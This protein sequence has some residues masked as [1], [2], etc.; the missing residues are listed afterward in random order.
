MKYLLVLLIS[1]SLHAETI[2]LN[3]DNTITLDQYYNYTTVSNL[4]QS[5]KKLDSKLTSK[6]PI[7][8]VL[9]SGGGS[10]AAGL[11][12]IENLNNLN[13]PV[14]TVTVFAASMGF[15]TVQGL[16]NRY[17]LKNGTLMTHKAFGGFSGEF[18][19]QLDSRYEYYLRKLL[20]M[21]KEVVARTNGVH[22]LDSYKALY[23]NEYWCDGVD[24][25][26]QGFADKVVNV[27]CDDSLSGTKEILY[28]RFIYQGYPVEIYILKSNCPLI[29][30]I[31]G[32][33]VYIN[34]QELFNKNT[35]YNDI[36]LKELNLMIDNKLSNV[37]KRIVKSEY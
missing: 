19:G 16:K 1:F 6:D 33:K 12:G 24:C 27:K 30:G 10:I 8:L 32:S 25:V 5:A 37:S 29:T 26:K 17:I 21:D 11:E 18:P 4:T 36:N 3:K 34:G 15:H 13:R 28:N 2:T 23:E 14:H 35:I 20:R 31:L 7:Y 22:T 9:D